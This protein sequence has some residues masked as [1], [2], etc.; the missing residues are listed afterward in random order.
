[1][2]QEINNGNA[3]TELLLNDRQ[4]DL[5]LLIRHD[6]ERDAAMKESFD[7]IYQNQSNILKI[8]QRDLKSS[9]EKVTELKEVLNALQ[10]SAEARRKRE[11]NFL[12]DLD[13]TL[14]DKIENALDDHEAR[15]RFQVIMLQ[16]VSV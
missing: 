2:I 7:S 10:S 15:T 16:R 12:E 6:G 9:E 4:K 11:K 1:M 3:S 14:V 13:E 8:F 5:D